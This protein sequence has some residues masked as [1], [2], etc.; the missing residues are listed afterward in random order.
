[1]RRSRMGSRWP[2]RSS[3]ACTRR[4]RARPRCGLGAHRAGLFSQA[5]QGELDK[6]RAGSPQD[7]D[8]IAAGLQRHLVEVREQTGRLSLVQRAPGL[9]IRTSI[10]R[11]TY[12]GFAGMTAAGTP[13]RNCVRRGRCATRPTGYQTSAPW[14]TT[15]PGRASSARSARA[16][17]PASRT[18]RPIGCTWRDRQPLLRYRGGLAELLEVIRLYADPEEPAL[19][20]ADVA[21]R[22]LA[23]E[24]GQ[25]WPA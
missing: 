11:R 6:A 10:E 14:P 2:D 3:S 16:S 5:V 15:T 25:E 22:L 1:M 21:A 24:T 18:R 12:L 13:P 4:A 9:S 19:G 20:A 7:M 17:P 23:A 8:A